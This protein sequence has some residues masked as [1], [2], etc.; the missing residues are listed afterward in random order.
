[1]ADDPSVVTATLDFAIPG[2]RQPESALFFLRNALREAYKVRFP[3]FDL[4][5][6]VYWQKTHPDTALRSEE[7]GERREEAQDQN[8]ERWTMNDERGM[9]EPGSLLSQLLDESGKLPLIGLIP[10]IART[11]RDQGIEGSG[12]RVKE[13]PTSYILPTTYYAT[14]WRQRGERELEDLPQMEPTAIVECLPKLWAADLKDALRATSHKPQATSKES[15]E[16]PESRVKSP[17]VGIRR[18]VLFIDAYEQLWE[19]GGRKQE[20]VDSRQGT[21]AWVREL[22]KQLP[23]ALW[24]I[25]GRQKLR[26][27]EVEQDWSNSLIQHELGTLPDRASRQFLTSC[28]IASE[29]IQDAI[30]KGSQGVPHYLDLAVDTLERTKDEGQRTKFQADAPD[31][32]ATQFMRHLNRPEL[33]A[34]QVLSAPRFWYCGLFENLMSEYE[35]GYPPT[36]YDDLSRFSFIS[37]GAAPGT[38]TMH[39]LMREA[40]QESQSPELRKRVHL[41]LHELYAKQLEGLGVKNIAEK[42]KAALTE[43]FYHGRQ[44]KSAEELWSWFVVA[45]DVFEK[46]SQYRLLIPLLREIAQALE[47]E[48]GPDHPDVATALYELAIELVCQG[49]YDEAEPLYRRALAILEKE[50][51]P[52]HP[53]VLKCLSGLAVLLKQRAR[54]DEAEVLARRVVGVLEREP[55]K[56]GTDRWMAFSS[57]AA[58][59]LHKGQYAEAE[60]LYRRALAITEEDLGPDSTECA[61]ALNNVAFTLRNQCRHSEAEPLYRRALAISEKNVGANHPQVSV[62]LDN[63]AGELFFLSRY[64]EAEPLLRRALRIIEEALGPDHPDTAVVLQNLGNNFNQE[65]RYAEAEPLLRRA[66][67]VHEKKGP[68]HPYTAMTTN[69][70]ISVL[71]RRGNYAE[72]ESMV[73]RAIATF[74]KKLGPDHPQ[75]AFALSWAGMMYSNQGRYAEA[76]GYLRRALDIRTR[77]VGPEHPWTLASVDALALLDDRRGRYAEAESLSRDVL[78]KRERV[79]GPNHAAVAETVIRLAG[80]CSRDGRYA[81][82]EALYRRALAIREKVFGPDHPFT[83]EVLEGLAK[84]YEQTGRTAEAE[85]LYRRA[86]AIR[87]KVFGPDYPFTAETLEGLAKVCE[88][89]GG[90]SEAQELAARAKRIRAQAQAAPASQQQKA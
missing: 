45:F 51:G 30:V 77:T 73:L 87:E 21:D 6:V 15:G 10:K 29:P 1:M 90:A 39:E 82:A 50:H 84:V 40:L 54:Y 9:L 55:G 8:D 53:L 23:E 67:A 65:G 58:A 89:T 71:I 64:A 46:A 12:D 57:L 85:A 43:A 66:L 52:E 68:D 19:T 44:A 70:L 48:L 79:L 5:Y 28:G 33:E 20:A 86:L 22:V 35:T 11:L 47:A 56:L 24:V 18:A 41:F 80:L 42:H 16:S 38:R 27:E 37:E 32:V 62:L 88:Q 60:D 78:A 63:L 14:W 76:E 74:E 13:T 4:A 36:A 26:W 3:S 69:N 72:A 34:L 17:E 25:C 61:V 75:T 83:A 7:G 49:E 31:E 59:L 2:Y 81:E